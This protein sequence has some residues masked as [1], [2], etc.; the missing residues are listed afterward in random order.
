MNRVMPSY[1][2]HQTHLEGFWTGYLETVLHRPSLKELMHQELQDLGNSRE[3]AGHTLCQTDRE[4][5][6]RSFID[7]CPLRGAPFWVPC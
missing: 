6:E 2:L 5:D 3:L 4:P 1:P 7:Y